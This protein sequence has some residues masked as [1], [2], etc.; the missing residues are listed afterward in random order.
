MN[1]PLDDLPGMLGV[2]EGTREQRWPHTMD[3]SVWVEKWR[4][5]KGVQHAD[6]DG[7]M[8]GWFAN[9]IMAGYDTA[10]ML[11]S[12]QLATLTAENKALR[13]E[14]RSRVIHFASAQRLRCGV[15][16]C[17]W[18]ENTPESHAPGCLAAGAA[19]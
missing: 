6:D 15:C 12:T 9:A 8:V 5:L 10:N 1:V 2:M 13:S 14:L 19:K 11:G 17:E 3:A 7:A 16:D 4:E 18:W